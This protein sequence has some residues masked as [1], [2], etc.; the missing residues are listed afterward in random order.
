M[1]RLRLGESQ[2]AEAGHV[3]TARN[4]NEIV[5][6]SGLSKRYRNRV[7]FCKGPKTSALAGV[8]G[9]GQDLPPSLQHT[10]NVSVHPLH[11]KNFLPVVGPV[12][13]SLVCERFD[14]HVP[15]PLK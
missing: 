8:R 1:L 5:G 4:P 11:A 15:V 6:A 9:L 2:Y 14:L 10:R 12:P 3:V 7:A 13:A